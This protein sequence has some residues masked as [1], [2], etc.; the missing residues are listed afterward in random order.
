MKFEEI[1]PADFLL[2]AFGHNI[3]LISMIQFVLLG[4]CI[5]D[6]TLGF[7][8]KENDTFFIPRVIDEITQETVIWKSQYT[9]VAIF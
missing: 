8:A 5:K 4:K 6:F 2:L 9:N 1:K 3:E 7:K